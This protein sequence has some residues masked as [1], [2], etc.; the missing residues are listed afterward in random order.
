MTGK[1]LPTIDETTYQLGDDIINENDD[2]VGDV[3]D[4]DEA[5][6]IGDFPSFSQKWEKNREK[7]KFLVKK[8]LEVSCLH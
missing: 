7:R 5:A 1:K 6:E 3:S 8:I 2:A 4:E